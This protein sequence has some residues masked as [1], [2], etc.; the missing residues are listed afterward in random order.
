MLVR[1]IAIHG[2]KSLGNKE[3]IISLGRVNCFI[4]A[5]GA[6]KSNFLEALGVLSA[7]ANGVID[8]ESLIR[9]GVRAGVP[10]LYK[11]SFSS[12]KTPPHI[13]LKADS[14]CNASYHVSLLNPLDNPKPNWNYKTEWLYDGKDDIVTRGV[15]KKVDSIS[16]NPSRGLA[17]LKSIDLNETNPALELIKILQDYAIYS[18][19]T[20]NLR[21][22]SPD[23]QSRNPIGLNGGQLADGFD[24][25][26]KFLI[27]ND[28]NEDIFYEILDLINWA[29]EITTTN[30][31][32][33]LLS[34]SI[35][36]TKNVIKF[37]DKFMNKS[38]NTLTAY[39]A[40]EGALYILYTAILCLH[41]D[42]PKLFSIDNLDQAL[43]PRLLSKLVSNLYKWTNTTNKQVCF[44]AHN[45]AALD[46]LDIKNKEIKLFAVERNSH[47][48]TEIRPILLD[49]KLEKL[50]SCYP[51]SR[52]W[53]T[54]ELGAIPNV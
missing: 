3:Q 46:G 30:T 32:G 38:R 21:G 20:P 50:N 6:G 48:V 44:T 8:D 9:R 54:G 35:P 5:N 17:A 11:S 19:N 53:L 2:F 16:L 4:G 39:D 43:N 23:H 15:R 52:L 36:R 22:I 37:T 7:A 41:P 27:L 28:E 34:T 47:G 40:S 25:L 26:K 29:N 33:D 45:P 1:R 18:P 14:D 24:S 12:E 13:G 49:E 31:P 10:K 42:S 51:L